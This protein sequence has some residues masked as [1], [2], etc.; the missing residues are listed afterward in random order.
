[1]KQ[2]LEEQKTFIDRQSGGV[3]RGSVNGGS[4]NGST[5]KLGVTDLMAELGLRR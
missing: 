2:K 1:M 3:P 5:E 4:S